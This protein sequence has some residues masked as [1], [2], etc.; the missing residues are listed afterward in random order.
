MNKVFTIRRTPRS[1]YQSAIRYF[2]PDYLATGVL[3]DLSVRG[4][5]ATGSHPVVPGTQII[6]HIQLS[7]ELGSEWFWVDKAQ[8][9]WAEGHTFGIE[10]L[11]TDKQ[12]QDF[13]R[14]ALGEF[15]EM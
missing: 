3:R 6:L 11:S 14:Y 2:G 7:E 13:L 12:A 4:G 5:R 10:F 15:E 9:R 1:G 8:V